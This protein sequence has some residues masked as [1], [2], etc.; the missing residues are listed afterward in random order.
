MHVIYYSE[1][2]KHVYPHVAGQCQT[3]FCHY[4]YSIEIESSVSFL[5]AERFKLFEMSSIELQDQAH[6]NPPNSE[7]EHDEHE[8][9]T[10]PPLPRV[11]QHLQPADRGLAAYKVLLAASV[12]EGV[13]FGLSHPN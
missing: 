10:S 9:S 2:A 11:V 1:L 6:P 7:I 13:L 5:H 8:S 4:I 3:E 12:F